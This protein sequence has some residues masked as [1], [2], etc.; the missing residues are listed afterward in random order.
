MWLSKNESERFWDGVLTD[1]KVRG[2]ESILVPPTDNL[3]GF[4][5]TIKNVFIKL[6]TQ[7]YTIHQT[8]NSPHYVI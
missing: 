7:I 3:N 2:F 1:L 6:Q 5:Q 8:R 4:T